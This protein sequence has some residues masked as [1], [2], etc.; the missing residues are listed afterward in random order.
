MTDGKVVKKRVAKKR[1][2]TAEIVK[3]PS[4]EGVLQRVEGEVTTTVK[5]AVK[6]AEEIAETV[7]PKTITPNMFRYFLIAGVM[8]IAYFVSMEIASFIL[9]KRMSSYTDISAAEVNVDVLAAL[10]TPGLYDRKESKTQRR[11][12][13][14]GRETFGSRG[15]P[16]LKRES[17]SQPP[18]KLSYG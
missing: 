4:K 9:K 16:S 8:I 3:T 15:R 11:Q 6:G 1:K 2:E 7:P 10:A 17:I 5:G 18:Q 13:R 14:E 12:S